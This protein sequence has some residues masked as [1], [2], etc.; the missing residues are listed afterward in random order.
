[1]V[2]ETQLLNL[3]TE[4]G[5]AFCLWGWVKS[6]VYERSVEAETSSSLAFWMLLP[7]QRN[8]KSTQAITRSSPM[9]CMPH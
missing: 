1:M 8:V 4:L 7:E 3:Q 2:T 9:T 6:E 5:S